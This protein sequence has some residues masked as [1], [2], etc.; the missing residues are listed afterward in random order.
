MLMSNPLLHSLRSRPIQFTTAAFSVASAFYLY[1]RMS[2]SNAG[3]SAEAWAATPYH[4][5]HSEWP[6]A[7][8]DFARHDP[9]DDSSFY[10]APRFVTHIDDA[11]ISS[12]KRYYESALPK[13]GRILDFCS[14]WISHMP[15]SI[16]QA[17]KQRDLNIVLMGMS[18]E[19]L[20]RNNL[21]TVKI[22]VQDLNKDATIPL[23][24]CGE[25]ATSGMSSGVLSGENVDDGESGLLDASTCVVSID[26]LIHPLNVL[27]SLLERTRTGGTVHLVVRTIRRVEEYWSNILT[28]DRFQI[29]VSQPKLY[30]AGSE[31]RK[32]SVSI[33][34]AITCIS[35]AGGRSR[36]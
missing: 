8:A 31:F 17:A 26:Y 3:V 4:P 23:T 12:L 5:R 9:D 14:S 28:S 21:P 11:A 24:V 22:L 15:D 35:L 13:K 19:E 33:W 20:E 25:Q 1:R 6:Y 2:N 32:R 18:Q 34:L 30:H 29:A 7:E 16:D 36:S 10:S 27:S